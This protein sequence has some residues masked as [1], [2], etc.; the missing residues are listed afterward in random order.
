MLSTQGPSEGSA[1][2]RFL[3]GSAAAVLL[4]SV[5]VI[6]SV[7]VFFNLFNHDAGWYLVAAS[8]LLNGDRLYVDIIEP[9]PPLIIWLSVPTV[10]FARVTGLSEVLA[11]RVSA[12]LLIGG[13]LGLAGWALRRILPDRPGGRLGLSLLAIAVLLPLAGYEFGEREHLMFAMILPYLVMAAATSVGHR[14]GGPLAVL[15]GVLAG[16][17][18]GFKPHFAILWLSVEGYLVGSGPGRRTW[19]RA[20]NLAVMATGFSCVVATFVLTPDYL[21]MVRWLWPIYR[22]CANVSWRSM[23]DHPAVMLSVIAWLCYPMVQPRGAY[24]E[25]CRV[26]LIVDLSLLAAAVLQSKGYSYHYY[27]AAA[28]AIV[29]LGLLFIESREPIA[30]RRA[31]AGVLGGGLAAALLIVAAGDR[32][33]DARLW[34]AEPIGSNT[35]YGR[36]ARLARAHAAGGSLFV[37]SPAVIDAFPMVNEVGATWASRHPCLWF[38]AGL[39]P[40]PLRSSPPESYRSMAAMSPAERLLFDSVIDDLLRDRPDLILVDEGPRLGVYCIQPFDYLA[41]YGRDPRFA[42]L[43]R[44]YEP[45][46]RLG[47]FHP[48]RRR[49]GVARRDLTIRQASR[50]R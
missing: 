45:L 32:I 2:S 3:S 33:F 12:L 13:S 42:A 31:W 36:L 35:Y 26:F 38:L 7:P 34:G 4:L 15:A 47:D 37:F 6:G 22:Y 30:D 9:N 21:V 25:L 39:Y 27:P 5:F 43:L 46:P 10:V 17:G 28:S 49:A 18:I 40:G 8:R 23:V 29:L 41:Y 19:L 14:F 44:E 24:R 11:F 48:Y 16:L 50:G 20:E 1:K